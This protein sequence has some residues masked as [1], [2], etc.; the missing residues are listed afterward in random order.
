MQV[1]VVPDHYRT[2]YCAATEKTGARYHSTYHGVHI[3]HMR[4]RVQAM[5]SPRDYCLRAKIHDNHSAAQ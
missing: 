2:E 5:A 1:S 3:S 4:A